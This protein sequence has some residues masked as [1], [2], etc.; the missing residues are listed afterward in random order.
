MNLKLLNALVSLKASCPY[1]EISL[2]F[3][4]R[5]HKENQN[6]Y[7]YRFKPPSTCK[8]PV[9]GPPTC[10][11]KIHPIIPPRISHLIVSEVG[12]QQNFNLSD[13]TFR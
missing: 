13:E 9:V 5:I 7:R 12:E 1:F 4:E 11:Q 3:L 2:D 10:K 6:K 8:P